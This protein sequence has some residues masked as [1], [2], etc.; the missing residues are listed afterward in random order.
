MRAEEL[1]TLLLMKVG[2]GII[3]RVTIADR[4]RVS[5]Q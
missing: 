5:G 3:T 1:R 4:Y 2:G